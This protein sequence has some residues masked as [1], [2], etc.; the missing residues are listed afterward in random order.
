M[1]T[2]IARVPMPAMSTAG[3]VDS[4]DP[5]TTVDFTLDLQAGDTITLWSSIDYIYA[6]DSATL[7]YTVDILQGLELI[8][9]Y[10]V[11]P[12]ESKLYVKSF[13]STQKGKVAHRFEGAK[14]PKFKIQNTGTYT[15][16]VGLIGSYRDPNDLQVQSAELFV[17]R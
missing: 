5:A 14:G 1:G 3:T 17:T 12:E 7:Y 2:E 6:K 16:S 9:T 4:Q 13:T 15:F 8:A 11:N 10:T